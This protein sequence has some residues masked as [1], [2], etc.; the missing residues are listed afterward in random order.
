M[1]VESLGGLL[2]GAGMFI[3]LIAIALVVAELHTQPRKVNNK[4]A[5]LEMTFLNEFAKKKGFDL[6]IEEAREAI[7]GDKT[8]KKRIQ[9]ELL[10]EFVEKQKE[11]KK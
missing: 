9:E 1:V 2:I 11:S 7:T 4:Y 6:S 8:F 5:L 3:L 10:R